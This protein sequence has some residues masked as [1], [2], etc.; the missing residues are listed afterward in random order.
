MSEKDNHNFDSMGQLCLFFRIADLCTV[1]YCTTTWYNNWYIQQ[2]QNLK[3][4]N[5]KVVAGFGDGFLY[6]VLIILA[7]AILRP[8]FNQTIDW[9]IS[10]FDK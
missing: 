2:M 9:Q 5:R 7:I 3:A 4:V 8:H 1:Y 6:R 10:Y